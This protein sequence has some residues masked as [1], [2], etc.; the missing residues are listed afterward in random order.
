MVK[1]TCKIV[2]FSRNCEMETVATCS[3]TDGNGSCHGPA[4]LF[5]EQKT[6]CHHQKHRRRWPGNPN[7]RSKFR[8]IRLLTFIRSQLTLRRRLRGWWWLPEV[9]QMAHSQCQKHR[10]R[11]PGNPNCSSKFCKYHVYLPLLRLFTSTRSRLLFHSLR[12][13]QLPHTG[14]VVFRRDDM[15][16]TSKT[17]L[18]MIRQP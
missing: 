5:L 7:G 10:Q 15:L 17:S 8:N 9:A 16:P 11:Q 6:R 3:R 12:Q 14:T 1:W 4:P 2:D 18:E 13:R